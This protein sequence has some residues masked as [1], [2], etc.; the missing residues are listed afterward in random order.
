MTTTSN[1]W[2][3]LGVLPHAEPPGLAL[4]QPQEGAGVESVRKVEFV[5]A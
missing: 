2:A 5:R 1:A 3:L 4:V